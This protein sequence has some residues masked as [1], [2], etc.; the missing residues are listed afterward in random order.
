MLEFQTRIFPARRRLFER[1]AKSQ[2]PLAL[3]I[4]CADSRI[5]PSLITHT[6]PGSIFVERNPGGLVPLYSEG[7]TGG[8]SAS[9]EYAVAVLNVPRIVVC[10]HSDC[11]A[12]KG[13]LNPEIVRD[14]PA[15]GH[16]LEHGKRPSGETT[17]DELARNNVPVQ[18]AN[19]LTHPS[20][21][22]SVAA[23][24]LAIQGWFYDIGTGEV[25]FYPDATEPRPEESTRNAGD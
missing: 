13:I 6:Q 23:G 8:V 1:L 11:G 18:I 4:T 24:T 22:R 5:A 10:G 2:Q 21:Q 19:L 25:T 20:V 12:M 3:F 16:W 15:V 9:I 17:A 7:F 14:L